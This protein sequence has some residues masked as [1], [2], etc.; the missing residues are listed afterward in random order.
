M[1]PTATSVASGFTDPPEHTRLRKL[2]TPG[3]HDAPARPAQARASTGSSSN[4]STRPSWPRRER[5]SR[6]PGPDLR[7]PDP[8]PGDLRAPRACADEDRETFR[9]L[10]A[11]RFDVT[12]GGQAVMGAVGGSR[13][14]L[15]RRVRAA[16]DDPGPGLIG[17]IIR[18]HGDEISDFD[19]GGLADG[20]FTG[21][22]ET[23]ASML[24]LG[25]VVL[26]G[27]PELYD[28]LV[29]DPDV[30]RRRS[31]RSCSAPLGRPG[32]VP[33]LRQ[34]RRRP[35]PASTDQEGR[36]ASSCTCRP[37]TATR[38]PTRP[39]R[40]S[41]P[42]RRRGLAP[43]LRLRLPPL[44][45]RRAGPDGAARGVPRP[46]AAL[47]RPAAGRRRPTTCP[48]TPSRSST[49]SSRCRSGFTADQRRV[50]TCRP[51]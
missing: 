22:L 15:L 10:G 36:R 35:W 28:G 2:L 46:G 44:R 11:A 12:H 6:R 43:G 7:L 39:A 21:G 3:V 32:R 5:R 37:P 14:F 24:A 17:Q 38:A 42:R 50:V 27:R 49:A 48:T 34:G 47:P 16:A 1:P 25:T 30:R 40:R 51:A 29:T 26:L 31:S 9:R 41:T 18:E 33:A 8:V 4:S 13:E 45:R 23:S 20:A 19:L